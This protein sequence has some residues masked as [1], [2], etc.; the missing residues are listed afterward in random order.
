MKKKSFLSS[1]F[2]LAIAVVIFSSKRF[3]KNDENDNESDEQKI[4]LEQEIFFHGLSLS[5]Y[6]TLSVKIVSGDILPNVL[7]RANV[8]ALVA[9][10]VATLAL[11]Y[12]NPAEI[13][14][15]QWVRIFIPKSDSQPKFAV[16]EV[17][18]AKKV[19]FHLRDSLYVY[20]EIKEI[21][22]FQRSAGA[23]IHNSLYQD[24]VNQGVPAAVVV[25]LA[26]LYA[27]SIDFFKIQP[28]DSI[29]LIFEQKVVDDTLVMGTGKILAAVLYHNN[30]PH[31]GFYYKSSDGK[32]DGYYNEEAEA[33]K[34]FFL[35]APLNFFKITSRYNLRRFHPV[36][37]T[38]KPHLG[39]DYAA[40]HG[41]PIMTT[42]DGVIEAMGYT[43][44][45]GN[46]VKVKHNQTYSTQYLHMS[47]FK[48]GLKVGSR[49]RQ[50]DIIGFVGS[51]GLA[52]G[53]HVCYR[54]WK[55]G[56]QVDPLA[57]D[58]P[59]SKPMDDMYKEAYLK[60]IKHT[61]IKLDNYRIER[62]QDADSKPLTA[63]T[64]KS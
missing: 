47:K 6:D 35:K 24:L 50:G 62:V 31:Y 46:Y 57:I 19:I 38:T 16:M 52:T 48:S 41:T 45:N 61:K 63:V 21:A 4:E 8:D 28:N 23:V 42:A 43:A 9:N 34:S 11:K 53:P 29:K 58:L 10:Q 15:G 12:I 18:P 13:Q 60:S 44:G 30:K 56:K 37:K 33:L 32:V 49:V 64:P 55:N 17:H 25:K 39:T 20:Q 36:L 1:V 59:V 2:F 7:K 5:E 3:E 40:P 26:D 27:W 51:T 54:F 14:P 22:T